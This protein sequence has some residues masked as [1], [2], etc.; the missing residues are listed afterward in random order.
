M[1]F[2]SDFVYC[3]KNCNMAQFTHPEI[4][5][6]QAVLIGIHSGNYNIIQLGSLSPIILIRK[7]LL[8]FSVRSRPWLTT[9]LAI[10]STA[11]SWKCLSFWG[12]TWRH[13]VFCI[14]DENGPVFITGHEGQEERLHCIAFEQTKA[15]PPTEHALV[16]LRCEKFVARIR[17]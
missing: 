16:F 6:W 7:E 14:Q 13:S 9:I 5:K 12:S 8:N 17:W 1:C 15:F 3:D 11:R 4:W 2:V 10:R